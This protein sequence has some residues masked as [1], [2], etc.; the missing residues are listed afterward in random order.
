MRAIRLGQDLYCHRLF[1]YPWI[2]VAAGPVAG[3]GH[4]V[5]QFSYSVRLAIWQEH[6]QVNGDLYRRFWN[7]LKW[8]TYVS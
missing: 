5:S 6:L 3:I 1:I 7:I 8:E 4:L 2:P